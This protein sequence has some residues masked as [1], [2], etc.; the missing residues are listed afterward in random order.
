MSCFSGRAK[1]KA[2]AASLPIATLTSVL[3]LFAL[4]QLD[5]SATKGTTLI[6][7]IFSDSDPQ[8]IGNLEFFVRYGVPQDPAVRCLIIVQTNS[9]SLVRPAP[10]AA[11]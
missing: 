10:L 5:S 2:L 3:F 9:A 7:H 4:R 8:Y 11:T 1:L 6:I